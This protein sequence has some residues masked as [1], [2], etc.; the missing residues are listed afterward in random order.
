MGES[1]FELLVPG[2]QRELFRRGWR[3][4]RP[5]Q[6]RAIRAYLGGDADAARHLLIMAETAG[7]KTEAAFL[8]VLSAISREEAGSVRAVYVGPLKALI[9]DQFGRVEDL[10]TFLDV[11]VHRW[12]GDVGAGRKR[13]LV[14]SPGGVLLITPESLESLLVNRTAH[15]GR[16]F[17]GLRAIV[18]DEVHAF[19]DGERGLHLASLLSRVRRCVRGA[20][21]VGGGDAVRMIGLSATVGDAQIARRYLCPG[22][23]ERVA[24]ISDPGKQKE[25]RLRVHAYVE[26][27]PAD[28]D[29]RADTAP[30]VDRPGPS[31]RGLLRSGVGASKLEDGRDPDPREEVMGR[32]ADD[33]VDHFA[34][35]T[36][37]VFA[38]AKGDIEVYAD[39]ARRRCAALGREASFIVHHGSL[40]RDVREEAEAAMKGEDGGRQGPL[41]AVCSS[42]LEMGIDI[43]S[44]WMVGQVGAPWSVASFKQRMGRSGRKGGEAR[45]LRG[46]VVCEAEAAGIGEAGAVRGGVTADGQTDVDAL[47]LLPIELLQ[48]VAVCE[49]MLKKWVEPPEPSRLD[50]STLAQQVMSVIAQ[51]GAVE[52]GALHRVLCVEGAFGGFDAG[53]FARVLRDLGAADVIEQGADGKLILGLEGERIRA[54]RD[55]YA[56]FAGR[57]EFAVIAGDRSIGSVPMDALPKAGEHIVFAARRWLVEEVDAGRMAVYVRAAG[58]GGRPRFTGGVGEVHPRVREEMLA[59]LGAGDAPVYLDATAAGVLRA[60]REAA[61]GLGLARRGLVEVSDTSCLWLTWTG[62]PAQRTLEALLLMQGVESVDRRV[63]FACKASADEVRE[64]LV[65]VCGAEG[66]GMPAAVEIA[67]HVSPRAVRKY[68][69]LFGEAL[70][71]ESIAADRLDVAGAKGVVD[72]TI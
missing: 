60:A 31:S 12:H 5:I 49:L 17:G 62:T 46:Y 1:A 65:G 30:S 66:T 35:R 59:V 51:E 10:A 43:G 69:H 9:N 72:E 61:A 54:G 39:L 41:V 16:L 4:L 2:L 14:E 71:V 19:L 44:V 37:L 21:G 13:G 40:A 25:V 23:P 45:R 22:D 26:R 57:Q 55:F 50:L 53:L 68:D 58:R 11:P 8:P 18:I 47:D 64:R 48:T 20:D 38:N 6:E 24:V 3:S 70:L 29:A 42:T 33:L 67:G 34:G 7:G 63:G 36:G 27:V 52:A 32:I 56:A 28:R 15:L